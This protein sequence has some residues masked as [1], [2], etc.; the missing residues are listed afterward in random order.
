M[1]VIR[2]RLL[3]LVKEL[4]AVD[5]KILHQHMPDVPIHNIRRAL[6]NAEESNH[7]T[8]IRSSDA[9]THVSNLYAVTPKN[10][11][12]ET[13]EE[14]REKKQKKTVKPAKPS[15]VDRAIACVPNSVF[16]LANYL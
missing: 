3:S 12:Y 2:P 5:A 14:K 16:N 1:A 15:M 8:K 7:I 4:G 13:Q 11:V 6:E 9:A 10:D